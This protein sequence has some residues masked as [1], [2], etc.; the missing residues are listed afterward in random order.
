MRVLLA[1]LISLVLAM[2]VSAEELNIRYLLIDVSHPAWPALRTVLTAR[3]NEIRPGNLLSVVMSDDFSV[4]VVKIL[5]ATDAWQ[6]VNGLVN[7]PAVW[8]IHTDNQFAKDLMTTHPDWT[9]VRTF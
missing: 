5:G 1:L 3:H 6:Q 9:R 8:E 7:H 4:A 2:P